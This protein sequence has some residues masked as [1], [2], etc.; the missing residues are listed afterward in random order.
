VEKW[1]AVVAVVETEV[2]ADLLLSEFQVSSRPAL[3][4]AGF[5]AAFPCP[6]R[7]LPV[8]RAVH[9]DPYH[10]LEQQVVLL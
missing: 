4:P 8:L 3:T 1:L 5:R 2:V 6:C 9:L 10:G 7:V